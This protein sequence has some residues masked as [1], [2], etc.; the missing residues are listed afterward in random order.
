M[1]QRPPSP[2]PDRARLPKP[3]GSKA[4]SQRLEA[5][6]LEAR[7]TRL[8]QMAAVMHGEALHLSSRA[9]ALRLHS[10]PL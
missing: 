4:R 7:A 10:D 8:L 6:E 1:T 5:A 2:T 9:A 3:R